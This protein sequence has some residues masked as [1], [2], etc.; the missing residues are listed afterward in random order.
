MKLKLN[1]DGHQE[2]KIVAKSLKQTF[3]R[4]EGEFWRKIDQED[5]DQI[6]AACR[7]LYHYYTGKVLK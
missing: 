4:N 6:R 3:E 1:L 5:S 7:V 2:D